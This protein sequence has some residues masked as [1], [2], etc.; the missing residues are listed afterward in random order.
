M[1]EKLTGETKVFLARFDQIWYVPS[2]YGKE[3]KLERP[4]HFLGLAGFAERKL[5]LFVYLVS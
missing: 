1:T 4:G 5:L 3:A 2:R